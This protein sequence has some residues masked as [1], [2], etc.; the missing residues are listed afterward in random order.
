MIL[1]IRNSMGDESTKRA[2]QEYLGAKLSREGQD[3]EDKL[4]AEAA[5]RLALSVWRK[6]AQTV[7]TK[8]QEWNAVTE[9]QTFSLKET[10]LGDLRIVCAGRPQQLIVHYDSR[11]LLVIFKNGGRP[12]HEKD[13]ILRIEGFS[14]GTVRDAHLVRNEQPVNLDM[15]ILGELRVLAGLSRQ[16]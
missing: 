7:T 1:G 4:N 9:E 10:L 2:A 6:V 14:T 12:E 13:A 11:R 5:E 8:I 16:T 15:L 3:H